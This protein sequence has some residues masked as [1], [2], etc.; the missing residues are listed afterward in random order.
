MRYAFTVF[1]VFND[2]LS[3]WIHFYK[4]TIADVIQ[5]FMP[6]EYTYNY[7]C[8]LTRYLNINFVE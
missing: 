3:G 7:S 6:I 5:I 1:P 4:L 2:D 8:C